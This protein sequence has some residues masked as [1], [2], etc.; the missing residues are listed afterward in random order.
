MA[1]S[2]F[3]HCLRLILGGRPLLRKLHLLMVVYQIWNLLHILLETPNFILFLQLA[4]VKIDYF[5]ELVVWRLLVRVL[6]LD[7]CNALIYIVNRLVILGDLILQ[8]ALVRS[9]VVVVNVRRRGPGP[10]VDQT[11][12]LLALLIFRRLW[13]Q[14]VLDFPSL[15]HTLTCICSRASLSWESKSH[16]LHTS[17]S[18]RPAHGSRLSSSTLM[19]SICTW[20]PCTRQTGV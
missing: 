8:E 6:F 3:A 10:F 15:M 12:N 19:W 2:G 14:G 18:T 11:V 13:S 1:Q 9:Q 20:A 16:S 5:L 17:S 7:V 4:V